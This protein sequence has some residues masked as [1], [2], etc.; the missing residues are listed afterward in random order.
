MEQT[1]LALVEKLDANSIL[2]LIILYGGW[3]L[4]V[5]AI[6]TFGIHGE[7]VANSLEL[8]QKDIGELKTNVVVIAHKVENHGERI[9]RLE[10][11]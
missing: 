11:K 4:T 6:D 5:R 3:K 7:K 9:E 10:N 8:I 2:L 1:I